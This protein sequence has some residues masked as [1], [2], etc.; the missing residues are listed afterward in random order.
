MI[1]PTSPSGVPAPLFDDVAVTH[2]PSS[3][4]GV[5][6]DPI[7]VLLVDDHQMF[8]DALS[9]SLASEHDLLPIGAVGTVAEAVI[10]CG[11]RSPDVI[12]VDLRVPDM[13]GVA[14]IRSLRR[15]SP[16]SAVVV[17]TDR[18]DAV[19]ITMA[20]QAGARG[21]VL[22]T[23][24][25]ED[26]VVTIRQVAV[27]EILFSVSDMPSMAARVQLAMQREIEARRTFERLTAREGQILA[28]LAQG[29]S[30]TET[31]TALHISPLTVRSHVKSILA[32]LGV[33]SK[34]E[35][36]SYALRNGLVE[37]ERPA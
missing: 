32:K 34:L 17:V 9:R 11:R 37:A 20:I 13:L 26:L 27:G 4:E 10:E 28:L 12:L 1:T 22:K 21:F 31:A 18:D 36:V 14:G 8:T 2:D 5:V 24:A 35:A 16:G 23:Q 33:H 30:T 15:V 29:R 19:A 25:V 6:V 7:S 3:P